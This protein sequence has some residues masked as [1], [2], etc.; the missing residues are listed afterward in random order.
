[1][2]LCNSVQEIRTLDF[3]NFSA[4]VG[5]SYLKN[6]TTIKMNVGKSF[7]MPLAN[8]LASDGVNYHMYRFE[9]GAIDLDSEESYQLDLDIDHAKGTF[10]P[11]LVRFS[12]ISKTSST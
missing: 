10:V 7:R 11:G 6:Y 2:C 9:R 3:G 12:I 4:S 5:F 1:M 8:E